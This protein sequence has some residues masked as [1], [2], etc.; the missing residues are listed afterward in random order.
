MIWRCVILVGLVVSGCAPTPPTPEQ[1]AQRCEERA[2]AAQ[3]PNVGLTLGTNSN[4][5]P[6][7]SGSIGITSDYI[8]GT[9]PMALYESC[10]MN[11]T[12]QSPIRPPR[13]RDI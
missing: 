12:G 8:R 10:V 1:A 13:L 4:S 2:R 5:G 7:A 6:F 11:L 9:D 3:A